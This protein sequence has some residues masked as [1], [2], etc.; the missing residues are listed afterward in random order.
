M[1]S[2]ALTNTNGWMTM[3]Q[4]KELFQTNQ[5]STDLPFQ[6][7]QIHWRCFRSAIS[8]SI[9]NMKQMLWSTVPIFCAAVTTHQGSS[10]AFCQE[11]M[12]PWANVTCLTKQLP[13]SL[14][15]C[16][17]T[18][19]NILIWLSG[20]AI[21]HSTASGIS[22]KRRSLRMRWTS[23]VLLSTDTA[24][25]GRSSQCGVT[26]E[27]SPMISSMCLGLKIVV[28]ASCWQMHGVTSLG[29]KHSRASI[30]Q[31]TIQ[32]SWAQN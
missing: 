2:A 21:T 9:R 7:T 30:R 31:A 25:K 4:F 16:S 5:Q 22:Q 14:T 18:K 11:S 29:M 32:W 27:S 6:Q 15:K 17:S 12:A 24:S 28:C 10:M 20:L 13:P 3:K 8:I 26:T 23:H 1:D 19:T